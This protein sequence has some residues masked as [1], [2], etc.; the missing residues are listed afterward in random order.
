MGKETKALLEKFE[1]PLSPK[2]NNSKLYT[3]RELSWMEF[4]KR[5]LFQTI[6]KD[7]PLLERL[8]FL[9]I[10]TSNLDEFIMVRL[11]SVLNK[12]QSN[13]MMPELSGM[14]PYEEAKE[15]IISIREFKKMQDSAYRILE[16]KL[17]KKDIQICR[18]KDLNKNEK[19]EVTT[20]F[21]K[22]IFPL[23][24]PMTYTSS[25]E[26]PNIK[27]R[28][29]N[30]VVSLE[31][32]ANNN[33]QVV[34]FISLEGFPKKIYRIP[35]NEGIKFILL[36]DIIYAFLDRIYYNKKIVSY[37]SIKLLRMADVD[38][39]HN[40]E[41]YITDRIKTSIQKRENSP[42][43]FMDCSDKINKDLLKLLMKIFDLNKKVVYMTE[44]PFDYTAF[45][46][47]SIPEKP[48]LSYEPFS[49]QYPQELIGEHDMF[50][51]MS[52]GDIL[53]H[54][55]YHDY[56][57]VIKFLEHSAY[58]KDVISIK[59]TLYRVSSEDSPIV[60]ALCAAARNG[61]QVAIILEIKARFDESRNISLIDKLKSSGCKLIYGDESL[62]THCKFIVVTRKHKDS[63]KIYSHIA[64]GNYNEKTSKI[65]TDLSYFTSKFKIGQDLIQVFNMLSGFSEPSKNINA[66][67]FSPYNIRYKLYEMIDNE[68]KHVKNKKDGYITIK[69]NSLCDKEL[70]DKLYEASKKGVRVTIF[71]RGLC[72]MKPINANI[73]IKS[74]VGRFLEHSRIYYF[75]NGGRGD[76]YISSADLL[77]RNLDRR[78]ELL[79]PV[80]D[81]ECKQKLLNILS[82][83]YKD[84]F[85]TFSM[86]KKGTYEKVY[87]KKE[88]DIHE[89]FM[90]DA[91]S[92]Y[93][94]KNIPKLM[95]VKK[96]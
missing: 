74:I 96:K 38:V 93:K 65:Y 70:I 87:D 17:N 20:I 95:G 49:P 36:E 23:I 21:Y 26:F 57:P 40:K 47:L 31:D 12:I 60:E 86:T 33:L 79:L 4:N 35:S 82:L 90:E 76:V 1:E 39:S 28:E 25:A 53:L 22:Q 42:V 29:K 73:K 24:T 13:N 41:V 2:F 55:P 50:T 71:C 67:Y 32:K 63:I 84:T 46:G 6:R 89:K 64:T 91:I 62:K 14:N 15:M 69:V 18:F 30:I 37:G 19:S 88:I 78:Y 16:K 10:S 5:V 56:D 54:H 48:E 9:G 61:K 77:S 72:S 59:Q 85:N 66:L 44:E 83:Y 8:N 75:S 81:M 51:A 80:K 7:I 58:D 34:S 43:I 11:G 94:M 27:S 45:S 92:K 52:K 3:N 68:V